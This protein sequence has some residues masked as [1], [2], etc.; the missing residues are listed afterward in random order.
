MRQLAKLYESLLGFGPQV[1]AE[2]TIEAITAH[3]RVGLFDQTFGV[4]LDWGLGLGIDHGS[5]GRHCSPRAFGHGGAMSSMA[6]AD[7]EHGVAVAI[8]CNGMP[9]SGDHYRRFKAINDAVFEDLGIASPDDPGRDKPLP[10]DGLAVS[11]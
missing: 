5:M 8:Q 2:Q 9:T 4:V 3:H 10:G 11:A 1:L 6:F 7:P